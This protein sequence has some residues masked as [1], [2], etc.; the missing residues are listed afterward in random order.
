MRDGPGLLP[1][2]ESC[3]D[4][5]VAAA[6]PRTPTH[7]SAARPTPGSYSTGDQNG[8]FPAFPGD[9]NG[10]LSSIS[11]FSGGQNGSFSMSSRF[12]GGQK[13]SFSK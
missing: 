11:R 12:S 3:W 2:W 1:D 6:V 4:A 5:A 7:P 9:Q 10:S 13:G 8:C